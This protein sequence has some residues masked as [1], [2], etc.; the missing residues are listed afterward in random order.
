MTRHRGRTR[1]RVVQLGDGRTITTLTT[2]HR[3]N[4]RFPDR[5]YDRKTRTYDI[6]EETAL[7]KVPFD[8]LTNEQQTARQRS[9]QVVQDII[10]GIPAEQAAE[11]RGITLDTARAHLGDNLWQENGK[12][13]AQM[14]EGIERERWFYSNGERVTVII[15]HNA[16][17]S[18]ISRYLQMVRYA[19]KQQNPS[20]LAAFKDKTVTDGYGNTY[21]FET[22]LNVLYLLHE[23][24]K[25]EHRSAIYDDRST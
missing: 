5:K 24:I 9:M 3:F 1:K 12:W 18:L 8:K 11:Q 17:A 21:P 13:K 4:S 19:M 20:L 10:D 6:T 15:S 7:W 2:R 14:P 25:P 23:K 22:N 16:H